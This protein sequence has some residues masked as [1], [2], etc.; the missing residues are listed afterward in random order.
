MEVIYL[1]D[2]EQLYNGPKVGGSL[3]LIFGETKTQIYASSYNAKGLRRR[4]REVL[5]QRIVSFF[6][7]LQ[8]F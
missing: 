3:V 8:P 4:E 1:S 6:C 2:S 7:V 5:P